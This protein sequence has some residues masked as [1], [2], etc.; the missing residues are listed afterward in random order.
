MKCKKHYDPVCG[1]NG[2]TYLNECLLQMSACI[3]QHSV[4]KMTEG[5]CE[6]DAEQ[7]LTE[8]N[9]ATRTISNKFKSNQKWELKSVVSGKKVPH[10]VKLRLNLQETDCLKTE[11]SGSPCPSA[12]GPERLCEATVL[13]HRGVMRVADTQCGAS[14]VTFCSGCSQ[15]EDVVEIA[16]FAVEEITEDFDQSNEWALQHVAKVQQTVSYLRGK[17]CAGQM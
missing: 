14:V 15:D 7:V 13:R 4:K 8:V 6:V 17:E 1:D 5:R 3:N 10:G 11:R 9:F 2:K 12:E 16:K